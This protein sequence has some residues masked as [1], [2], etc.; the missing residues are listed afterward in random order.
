MKARWKL[1]LEAS[2][3]EALLAVDLYNQ[4][5]RARRLEGFFVHI[6]VAWLYLFQARYQ[7]GGLS[8]F[9]RRAN[10]RYE[11]VDGERK[12]WDLAHFV[13]S[14]WLAENEP[15]RKNLEL[16]IAL[17]NKI[18]HRFE[19]SAALATAGYAQALLVNYDAEL[20]DTFGPEHSLGESLRF[21][22]FIGALT[23]EGAARMAAAQQRL[24]K[25]ISKFLTEFQAPLDRSLVND[26]RYEFRLNLLPKTGPKADADLA[27]SFVRAD[28]L[29]VE[30]REMLENLDKAGMV[31]VRDQIR[32]VVNADKMKPTAAADAIEAAIPFRFSPYSHFPRAWQALNAR[33]KAGDAHP[34]RTRTDLCVF[35]KPHNDYL[36]TTAFVDAVVTRVRTEAGFREFLGLEPDIRSA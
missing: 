25:K 27:L 28:D 1:T 34:E 9:Y 22:V 13:R 23:R 31:I 20:R 5:S 3:D 11:K 18:E 33:P 14:G 30:Q 15:V 19:D 7:R 6:H 35:D 10:G 29:T 26:P 16:T 8:Y 2:R 4:P 24:P 12:T 36:Y 32:E 21:P 17:R